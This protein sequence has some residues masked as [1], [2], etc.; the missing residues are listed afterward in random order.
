MGGEGDKWAF[1][2]SEYWRVLGS[3]RS[4]ATRGCGCTVAGLDGGNLESNENAYVVRILGRESRSWAARAV[5]SGRMGVERVLDKV[6]EGEGAGDDDVAEAADEDQD[7]Q[8][9]AGEFERGN[10]RGG[11]V[12]SFEGRG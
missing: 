7:F 1:L 8:G 2:E 9:D 10:R 5:E 12:G 6:L 11:L 3:G 4:P